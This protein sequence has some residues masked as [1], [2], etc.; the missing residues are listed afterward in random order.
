MLDLSGGKG[1]L[2]TDS[3]VDERDDDDEDDDDEDDQLVSAFTLYASTS[4]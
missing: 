1:A 4:C 2:S 3:D